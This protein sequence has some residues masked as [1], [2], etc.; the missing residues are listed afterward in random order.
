[1]KTR[2]VTEGAMAAS[3][4]VILSLLNYG[5]G[6]FGLLIPV[7]LALIVYRHNLKTAIAVSLASAI[8]S[9]LVLMSPLIGL[10]IM[11]VGITGIALGLGLKEGFSHTRLVIIG[12]GAAIIAVL[13]RIT[14]LAL[15]TDYDFV[16]EFL[17]LWENLS[18][19][20]LTIWES[21]GM[22]QDLLDKYA[23]LLA[24]LPDLFKKIIPITILIYGLID[25]LIC[26]FF[27]RVLLKRFGVPVPPATPFIQWKLP[28]YFVWGYIISKAASILLM[29]YRNDFL[30]IIALNL[31]LF[32]S[33]AFCVQGLAILW[34]YLVH[35]G[36][37]KSLCVIL[38]VFLLLTGNIIILNILTILGILD[39]WFDV[40][41]LNKEDK[42]EK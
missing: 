35:A 4:S 31:D 3:I 17:S 39:I 40:R 41:K 26:L 12:V 18:Q 16:A 19:Q 23:D 34:S 25:T 6:F 42:E 8:I 20:Y 11:I 14:T 27:L 22:P 28:W 29:Y 32:F 9:S 10:D 13:L 38:S 21:T 1:M 7:P 36:V 33:A 37:R 30:Q 2:A 24:K 15:I 5:F